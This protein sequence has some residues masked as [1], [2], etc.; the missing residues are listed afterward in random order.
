MVADSNAVLV[1]RTSDFSLASGSTAVAVGAA[2]EMAAKGEVRSVAAVKVE[3]T[4]FWRSIS[5]FRAEREVGE[6]C[7]ERGVWVNAEALVRRVRRA[8]AASL[9]VMVAA[10]LS[11][12]SM[13]DA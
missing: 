8:T 13:E 7:W 2:L 9:M 3:R 12:V 6:R 11:R 5:L 10:V 4:S 1:V